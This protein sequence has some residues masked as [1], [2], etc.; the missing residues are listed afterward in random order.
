MERPQNMKGA[1]SLPGSKRQ[2]V[3]HKKSSA[4]G[5]GGSTLD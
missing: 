4:A 5:A 1:Y 3:F 2:G